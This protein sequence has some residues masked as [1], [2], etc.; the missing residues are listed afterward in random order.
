MKRHTIGECTVRYGGVRPARYAQSCLLLGLLM[1]LAACASAPAKQVQKPKHESTYQE[2]GK[3]LKQGVEQPRVPPEVSEALL[4]PVPLPG[5]KSGTTEAPEPH[6]D[7]AATRMPARDFFMSLMKG[8]PYN[9]V[10]HPDVSGYI[11]L[12]L[13]DV[14]VQE[15]LGVVRDIYGYEFE[16]DKGIYMIYPPRLQSRIF[17]VSYLNVKRTGSSDVRI[18]TGQITDGIPTT[19]TSNATTT[20]GG[21]KNSEISGSTVNTTSEADFWADLR[22]TLDAIVGNGNGRKVIVNPGAGIV[23]VHAY[24]AELRNVHKF[25][26]EIQ[27]VVHRE[28]ILEAKVLEVQLNN[29]FQTGVNWAALGQLAQSKTLLAAQTGGGTLFNTGQSEIAGNPGIL[30]PGSL[31]QVE[32]SATS[33]FGGVFS[34][35]LNLNDFNGFIELLKTQG[36]VQVLSSPRISTVNNQKAVIKVGTDE[37][38]VTNVSTTTTSSAGSQTST[39][40]I[41]LTPFFSG[42]ALDVTPQISAKGNVILHIHPS[43]SDVQDQTKTFTISGEQQELPLAL[44]SVRESDNVI[45]A[46]NGQI[47]M[48]GG[49]MQEKTTNEV[50]GVPILGDIP[51]FGNLFRH[52]MRVKTKSELIILL[53]PLVV[54][55]SGKEWS[56]S[57]EKSLGN[58]EDMGD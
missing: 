44:S 9:I 43:V 54:S 35:A 22:T 57:I 58:Y 2:I 4:P 15:V 6:F 18:T 41:T 33:A 26:S 48:I 36:D 16:R 29:K 19:Q 27:N 32:N 39:P 24:P 14:T 5:T 47:V 38:F 13:N 45:R 28:V 17:Q 56:Q 21:T 23:I 52:T 53:R 8:T 31:N 42:I 49:L 12:T 20:T 37:F 30:A 50:A 40:T 11:S 1:A 51:L 55:D 7:I 46:A 10:V 25:L 34:V 3:A